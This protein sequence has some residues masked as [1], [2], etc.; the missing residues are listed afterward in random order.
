MV[1]TVSGV[2]GW[3]IGCEVLAAG[4]TVVTILPYVPLGLN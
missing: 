2:I 1:T 4:V 3:V